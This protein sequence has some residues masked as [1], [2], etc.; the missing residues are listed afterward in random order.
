MLFSLLATPQNNG[1]TVCRTMQR[2]RPLRTVVQGL[3]RLLVVVLRSLL[4][5]A[6]RLL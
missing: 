2:L 3:R 1:W 5:Q 6:Q 4:P